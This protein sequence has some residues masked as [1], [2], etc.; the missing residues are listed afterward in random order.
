MDI[1]E[2][3]NPCGANPIISCMYDDYSWKYCLAPG[4]TAG[5]PRSQPS[6]DEPIPL[7]VASD[8]NVPPPQ[9][10][11][12]SQPSAG[13]SFGRWNATQC[14]CF[15]LGAEN[16]TAD[17][18]GRQGFCK[19]AAGSC[20]LEKVVDP[21]DNRYLTCEESALARGNDDYFDGEKTSAAPR[22]TGTL[23]TDS[24]AVA[25]PTSSAEYPE[26]PQGPLAPPPESRT[27]PIAGIV[28]GAVAAVTLGFVGL[29]IWRQRRRHAVEADVEPPH[30]KLE[31][32][33]DANASV[34]V[35]RSTHVERTVSGLSPTDMVRRGSTVA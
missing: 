18:S 22:P 1:S 4:E 2:T 32:P 12:C 34:E 6:V 29:L 17:A 33:S 23:P 35:L 26:G 25:T 3:Y 5:C 8:T 13:C 28:G 27:V 9:T 24:A 19:D 11:G 10:G 21:R 14:T 15:C 30:G 16:A 7:V 20:M 31:L